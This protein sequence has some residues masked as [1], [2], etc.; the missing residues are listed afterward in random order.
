MRVINGS[1]LDVAV[2]LRESSST[3]GSHISVI[4]SSENFRQLWI[5]PGFAHGFSVLSREADLIY[6]T[7]DYYAPEFEQ[8]I[9]YDDE[10]LAIDW[11][12]NDEEPKISLKD[13][14]GISFRS[15]PYFP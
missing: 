11:N 5:P 1:I 6:K 4:L 2:D 14:K 10:N 7:T 9:I 15:A 8:C 3:F 12:L 13:A